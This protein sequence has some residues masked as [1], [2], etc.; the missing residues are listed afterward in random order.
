[1]VAVIIFSTGL[2]CNISF[3]GV[4]C[5]P[6]TPAG[7]TAVLSCPNYINKFNILAYARRDCLPTGEWFIEEIT[8]TSWTDYTSC[9]A[10][11]EPS[12]LLEHM[13]KI[14]ILYNVGYAISLTSL[15]TAVIL[16]LKLKKLHCE[17]NTIHI[18]LFVSFIL[19]A[20]ICFVKDAVAVPPGDVVYVDS[21]VVHRPQGSNWGCK[22]VY[23]LFQYSLTANYMW[24]FV[25]SLY[26]HTLIFFAMFLHKKIIKVYIIIGWCSP[27]L[28]VIPWLI[29]RKLLEDTMCWNTHDQ[30]KGYYWIIKGPIIAT[31][32][33]NL[34][35]F[36]N[37]IR[38]LFTKLTAVNTREPKTYRKLA[39]STLVLIPLFGVYYII[40]VGIPECLEDK[41]QIVRVY[42]EM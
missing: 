3:D 2:H 19:R 32:I 23:T 22:L 33:A 37:I 38:V 7:K 35:F 18:N 39:K 10:P 41:Y 9:H 36:I 4:M 20:I 17:R 30:D 16:M 28:C 42:T 29:V 21:S 34:F 5:W 15:L 11:T 25:E 31:I 6:F 8:N 24:I 14:R 13:P 1:M 40:F 26:L 12:L 27:L